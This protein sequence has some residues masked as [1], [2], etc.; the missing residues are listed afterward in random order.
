VSDESKTKEQLLAELEALKK[1]LEELD[2]KP[3]ASARPEAAAA[4]IL[5]TPISRRGAFTTWVAP[6]ILSVPAVQTATMLATVL[7]PGVAQAQITRRPTMTP[8][9]VGG[10]CLPAPTAAPTVAPTL[11]M[12][13]APDSRPGQVAAVALGSARA[14]SGAKLARARRSAPS[15]DPLA[16]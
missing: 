14:L 5:A 11:G 3:P 8:T 10:R 12:A 13:S 16:A 9:L 6:V 2:G 4:P 15:C 7:K 1:R